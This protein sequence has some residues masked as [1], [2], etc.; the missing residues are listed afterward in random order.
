MDRFTRERPDVIVIGAGIVGLTCARTLADHGRSV[1]VL[2][3][4]RPGSGASYAAAGML[5]PLAEV[6]EPGPFFDACRDSRDQWRDFAAELSAETGVDLDYDT[7]GAVLVDDPAVVSC[8]QAAASSLGEPSECLDRASLESLLPGLAPSFDTGL[9]MPGEHRISN[10]AVCRALEQALAQRGVSIHD[11]RAVR[12]IR[13]CGSH[14][15]V[16]GDDWQLDSACAVIAAGAWS[17]RVVLHDS[18]AEPLPVRPVRG[19]MLRFGGISWPHTGSVRS[20]HC[21]AVRRAGG[22]LLV[23]ATVD[24]VGFDDRTTSRGQRELLDGVERLFP[25]LAGRRVVASW[26]G[27]RPA[28]IDG[29]PYIGQIADSPIW[30]ATGHHRNGILLAPWTAH[31][32]ARAIEDD[33]PAQRTLTPFSPTRTRCLSKVGP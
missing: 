3:R 7:S 6:P 25:R 31:W 13:V 2:D 1:V 21:Y 8:F 28:T 11:G 23:G 20:A 33:L 10:R 18:R 16:E 15:S 32:L 12:G 4:H 17:G 5:A 30:L 14:V 9:L 26:S 29:L 27:L 22:G 24:E 19:E